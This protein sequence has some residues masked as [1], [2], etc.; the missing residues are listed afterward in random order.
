MRRK[1]THG[2]LLSVSLIALMISS[3]GANSA[4]QNDY[5]EPTPTPATAGNSYI[6]TS[7]YPD[8]E[9]SENFH[10]KYFS[11][12]G[13]KVWPG[14]LWAKG[15]IYLNGDLE[16]ITSN[17]VFYGINLD[18]NNNEIVFLNNLYAGYEVTSHI[19]INDTS[20][21]PLHGS[22]PRISIYSGNLI[23]GVYVPGST[24]DVEIENRGDGAITVLYQNL[25]QGATIT[26]DDY[27]KFYIDR[28]AVIDADIINSNHS[29]MF[30]EGNYAENV[31]INNTSHA[32]MR[33]RGNTVN[34]AIIE[35]NSG[36]GSRDS[37]IMIHY[38][39]A[40]DTKLI[41]DNGY[42]ELLGNT[43]LRLDLTNGSGGITHIG[44][45]F[46]QLDCVSYR[47]TILQNTDISNAGSMLISGFTS[48][49]GSRI[50]NLAGA[51]IDVFDNVTISTSD[52]NTPHSLENNG[53]INI[54]NADFSL[55]SYLTGNGTIKSWDS[56]INL[57]SESS[58]YAGLFD[59]E[60]STL[61][62]LNGASLGGDLNVDQTS[63][64]VGA[65]QA[66]NV[67]LLAG[68]YIKP[69][70]N[71][72]S[73][74]SVFD[75]TG[76]FS[77][78]GAYLL[79]NAQ[80]EGDNSS[81]D[82]I[83][84]GGD[85]S[86]TAT[87]IVS[88]VGGN[89]AQTKDGIKVIEIGNASNAVFT[90][91]GDYIHEGDEAVVAGAYA[92]KLRKGGM[93][94]GDGD[95]Y[96]H[97]TLTKPAP[98]FQGGVPLY[99]VYPQFLLGLNTLPSQRQR[100]GNRYWDHDGNRVISQGA[101]A[102][103]VYAPAQEAGSFTQTSGMWGRIEGSHNKV[104][105][106]TSTSDSVYDYNSFK[107]QAGADGLLNETENGKL[108]GGLTAH[109]T[110]GK[111]N[112]YSGHGDG[113]ISTDGYG[114]GGTLSWYADNGF[115]VDGQGQVTWYRSDLFSAI[116]GRNLKDGKS[117]GVG[118]A[119]SVEAGKRITIDDRWS[120]TPQAQLQYSSVDFD[121]FTD[122]FGAEVS[123]RK[124]DSLL[125]RLGASI[126][127]QNSWQNARGLT[128]R[129]V[130]YGI[131]NLYN[132]FLDGTRVEVS[133]DAFVNKNERFWGG[134]GIGG[135][136]NWDDDKYSVYGEGLINTSFSN[137]GDSYVYKGTVGLRMEW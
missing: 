28:N 86:G 54:F 39:T 131:A 16:Y 9:L 122:A 134:V 89:G 10:T 100:A 4:Q 55:S 118:Y 59:L 25:A 17:P 93:S 46:E 14:D 80:L 121:D 123:R 120:V 84:I 58:N 50:N 81:T 21:P 66:H 115:Y 38:N 132:E 94:P 63:G 124:G 113:D 95:W 26:N 98:L 67:N 6:D 69:S 61:R 53:N 11:G 19:G 104:R 76:D 15:G 35:N 5:G 64:L 85:T 70:E 125:G 77:S 119:L 97:S 92:Y 51:N 32:Y 18:E 88:N 1:N 108:I 79:L 135:S 24:Q 78:D 45:C 96:L 107:M 136:Y 42:L 47:K 48:I 71:N 7:V 3:P 99:E 62:F 37:E 137:F 128:D 87:V 30:I 133:G 110:R 111:L 68:G 75:I 2:L 130:I 105:P 36:S 13:R 27:G 83:V 44:D 8:Y 103:E 101:D 74:S 43:G 116:A 33:I 41:N 22:I 129:S 49:E 91:L 114:F 117:H 60:N 112:V 106:N 29:L 72:T 57:S 127:Y 126:D 82:K 20:T 12:T 40:N 65:G 109:Y 73:T 90:L 34:N 23:E 102:V 31:H 52:D 56:I